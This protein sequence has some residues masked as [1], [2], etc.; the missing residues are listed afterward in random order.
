LSE[1]LARGLKL[2]LLSEKM[3][4]ELIV[5]PILLACRELSSDTVTI[6][7]G[8]RLDVDPKV[9][10]QGECDF[11][12]A[13][14]VP[15]PELRSPLIS[16]VE[17]KKNDIESG[18]GQC[19]AQMVGSQIWNERDNHPMEALFG[20]VTTGEVWQFLRLKQTVLTIDSTRYYLGGVGRILAAFQEALK[21]GIDRK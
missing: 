14:T 1:Q 4:S 5:M 6:Y 3:R 11:I 8:V 13:R 12:V 16:I 10:L 18:L 7:S 20:C 2:P 19:V 9:G 15:L 17:A 21:Q